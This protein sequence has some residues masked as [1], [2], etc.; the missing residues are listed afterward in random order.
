M[1]NWIRSNGFLLGLLAAVGVAILF[2]GGG[3]SGGLFRSEIT[4][5]LGVVVIF[6]LQGM[7]LPTQS[8]G[9]GILDWRLHLF[10][11]AFIFVVIPLLV[12]LFDRTL[13]GSVFVDPNLRLGFLFLA[14]LPTTIFTAIVFTS[15]VKGNTAGALF[16]TIVS[17]VLGVLIVPVWISWV[18]S[19]EAR[20][21]FPWDLILRI[22]LFILIPLLAGQVL[23]LFFRRAAEE[24]KAAINRINTCIILFIVYAA[25]SNSVVSGLWQGH[26][27]F[28]VAIS[29]PAATGLFVLVLAL[30]YSSSVILRFS[31]ENR[32]AALFCA[33]QK[34]LAAGVPMAQ[35]IFADNPGMGIILLPI[36][37]Y[38]TIQLFAGGLIIGWLQKR[39]P[40]LK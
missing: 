4:T 10:V 26:G 16:N 8:L 40:V 30:V 6:L 7:I 17:N 38:H 11:H 13:G 32:M 20:G 3:A 5:Q 19:S 15:L 12:L 35:L 37:V 22:S 9:R 24:R 33:P 39:D 14:I 29:I 27:V 1:R 28:L 23:R 21:A 2:P 25:F 36:L 18:A 31:R 34:T